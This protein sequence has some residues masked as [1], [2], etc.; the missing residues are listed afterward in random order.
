MAQLP[1][2]HIPSL[3]ESKYYTN[4]AGPAPEMCQIVIV[5][6]PKGPRVF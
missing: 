6:T 5:L 2:K 3:R 4:I 1:N